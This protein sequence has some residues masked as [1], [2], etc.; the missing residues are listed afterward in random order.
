MRRRLFLSISC[1]LCTLFFSSPFS[2]QRRLP[3]RDADALAAIQRA[4]LA[5]GGAAIQ[6][7]QDSVFQGTLGAVEGSSMTSGDFTW[8]NSGTEFRYENP[9]RSGRGTLVSG[10]GRPGIVGPS[11]TTRL[12]AH[13]AEANLPAHLAPLVLLKTLADVRHRLIFVGNEALNGAAVIHVRSS[14]EADEVSAATTVRDWFFDAATGLPV[15]V[16]YRLPANS[17]A[18]EHMPAAVELS[19]FR[20]VS[21][22][23]VPF[24]ITV[25][26]N[27]QRLGVARI[28][29]VV[30]NTGISPSDFDLAG[31]GR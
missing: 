30:F 16:E 4:V 20:F 23:A 10:R 27:G 8:K 26:H 18:L 31:G 9:G 19:D 17:N 7:V 3:Q 1:V 12:N 6:Q 11:G 5:M 29:S 24:Q 13:M 22:I 28:S 21:G 15:R 2:A 25:Y 14:L